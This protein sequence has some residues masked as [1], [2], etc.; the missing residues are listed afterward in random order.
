MLRSGNRDQRL[1]SVHL[2]L[3]HQSAKKT[4]YISIGA[5]VGSA[6]VPG[7]MIT[8]Y[9]GETLLIHSVGTTPWNGV[10]MPIGLAGHMNDQPDPGAVNVKAVVTEEFLEDNRIFMKSRSEATSAGDT[11]IIWRPL[12]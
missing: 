10:W 12:R 5:A 2:D 11:Q 6:S 1:L 3:A 8:L 7:S 4:L 9:P